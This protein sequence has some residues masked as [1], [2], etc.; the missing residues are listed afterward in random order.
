MTVP[1]GRGGGGKV[2][3]TVAVRDAGDPGLARKRGLTFCSLGPNHAAT[4]NGCTY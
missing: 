3:R 4:T 1:M 2:G